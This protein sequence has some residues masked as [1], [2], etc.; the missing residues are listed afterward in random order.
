MKW[1]KEWSPL[2]TRSAQKCYLCLRNNLLPMCPERTM[3]P[4]NPPK[5]T[6]SGFFIWRARRDCCGHSVPLPLRGSPTAHAKIPSWDF[7][8]TPRLRRLVLFATHPIEQNKKPTEAKLQ[9]VFY[10]ARSERFE[11]PTNWFEASYSI[12]LSY[13][14]PIRSVDYYISCY[15]VCPRN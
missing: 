3:D 11:L 4:K 15:K 13:E 5:Q 14:R 6:F 9:R 1:V 7:G 10:L 12:Q 2:P 8:R